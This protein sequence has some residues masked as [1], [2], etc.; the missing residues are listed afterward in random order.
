MLLNM[1]ITIFLMNKET[2]NWKNHIK[3]E[4]Y[5]KTARTED[6]RWPIKKPPVEKKAEAEKSAPQK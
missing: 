1:K 3:F 6:S 2:D 5:L 4:N